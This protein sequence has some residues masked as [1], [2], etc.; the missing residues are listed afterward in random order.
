MAKDGERAVLLDGTLV[1]TRRRSG[2]AN[3][4]NS[5]GKHKTHGLPFLTLADTRGRLLW[6][7]A[8]RRGTC[9]EITAARYEKLCTRLRDLEPGAVAA[10]GFVGLDDGDGNSRRS[11]PGSRPAAASVSPRRRRS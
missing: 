9:T 7:S 11:S 3:R 1:R 2:R 10:L 4:K 8:A 6:I 5:S